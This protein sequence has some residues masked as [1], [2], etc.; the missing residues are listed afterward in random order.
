MKKVHC[1]QICQTELDNEHLVYCSKVNSNPEIIFFKLLN[2]SLPEL[3][4]ELEL[5]ALQQTKEKEK[6]TRSYQNRIYS[7]EKNEK[8]TELKKWSRSSLYLLI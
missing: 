3:E 5:E 2:G 6:K 7:R 4:L 8:K 1:V